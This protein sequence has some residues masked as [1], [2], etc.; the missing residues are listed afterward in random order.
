M[1][2]RI[3]RIHGGLIAAA[4][5]ITATPAVAQLG[6]SDSYQFLQAIRD[7]KG[8]EVEKLLNKP[9]TVIIDT[10]DRTTGETALHIVVKRDD[11]TYLRYL[12]ARGADANAKDDEGNTPLILASNTGG[13]GMVDILVKHGA[14]V[15]LANGRGETPLIR[16]VQRRDLPMVRAL[17]AAGAD[18]DQSDRIAGMSA[19]DYAKRD[20]RTGQLIALLDAK[21]DA[22]PTR[23]FG[24]TFGP[25]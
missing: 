8:D 10:H 15:N 5:I 13:T 17:L 14:N 12:L 20:D 21:A 6:Q 2:S 22:A 1:N 25:N 24:P 18:P 4:M 7:S 19:R 16:A 3:T 11:E 23:E 9:G